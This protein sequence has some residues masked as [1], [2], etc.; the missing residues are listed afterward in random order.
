M[1]CESCKHFLFVFGNSALLKNLDND[2]IVSPFKAEIRVLAYDIALLVL[3]NKLA[4]QPVATFD[5]GC[6]MEYL[7]SVLK[8]GLEIPQH[9]ILDRVCQGAQLSR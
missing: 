8:G 9:H 5:S 3:C 7:I 4:A 6:M 1:T 2:Q